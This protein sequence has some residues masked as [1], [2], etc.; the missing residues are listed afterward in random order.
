VGPEDYEAT[1]QDDVRVYV[2]YTIGSTRNVPRLLIK[3]VEVPTK[4]EDDA[5]P[6]SAFGV[7]NLISYWARDAYDQ[8][9]ASTASGGDG[10]DQQQQQEQAPPSYTLEAAGGLLVGMMLGRASTSSG[11]SPPPAAS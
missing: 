7:G 8:P 5:E 11:S 9:P 6:G 3:N 2:C 10:G 4:E 1:V